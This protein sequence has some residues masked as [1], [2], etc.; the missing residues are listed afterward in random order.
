[1]PSEAQ[2][3]AAIEGARQRRAD[4]AS[5]AAAQTEW[6]IDKVSSTVALSCQQRV[7]LATE[8]L[9]NRVIK[10]IS[11]PVT[12]TIIRGKQGRN[13]LGQFTKVQTYT[14]VTNRSKK[15]EFPKADTTQLMKTIFSAYRQE[16]AGNYAGF[17][18]TPIDYGVIL[19]TLPQLDRSF[20]VRTLNEER[21][22][23]LRILTGPI[24]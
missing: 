18:G 10:N 3:I 8:Y 22:R 23:I 15:G 7:R 2:R 16:G 17:V 14:R 21:D 11:R 5:A 12:K 6:F 13:A 4:R 19:E 9:K 20:L 1:M 24:K